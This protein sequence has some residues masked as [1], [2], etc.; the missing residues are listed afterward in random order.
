MSE[1][2][3]SSDRHLMRLIRKDK[4]ENGWTKCSDIVFPLVESLPTELVETAIINGVKSA[5][6]SDKGETVLDWT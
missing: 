3:N 2:L 6:L 4:A 5:R 1:K